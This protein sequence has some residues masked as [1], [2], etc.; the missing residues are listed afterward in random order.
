MF[1]N[2]TEAL[3]V[4]LT[5]VLEPLCDAD[6]A[7]LARYVLALLKKDKPEKDLIV[8]MKEQLDVFL[9]EETQPFLD[10]LFR[11]IKS[12]EYLKC[13]PAPAVPAAPAVVSNG[14]TVGAVPS[15]TTSSGSSTAQAQAA[16]TTP[17]GASANHHHAEEVTSSSRT[18]I[19]REFTPPLQESSSSGT[20]GR[21]S[22]SVASSAGSNYSSAAGSGGVTATSGS[23]TSERSTSSSHHHHHHHSGGGG[24][25]SERSEK[26][27]GSETTSSSGAPSVSSSSGGGGTLGGGASSQ[28]SSSTHHQQHSPIKGSGKDD[29]VS[30]LRCVAKGNIMLAWQTPPTLWYVVSVWETTRHPIRGGG[31]PHEREVHGSETNDELGAKFIPRVAGQTINIINSK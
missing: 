18:T 14:A 5:A 20:G 21:S 24:G 9:S 26:G 27:R 1:I 31:G 6:P 10:R 28:K 13:A 8:S 12:E 2:N 7:A 4:W 3:K 23:I 16:S 29:H 25:T 15:S 11:V 19:K 17:A 22:K 30:V